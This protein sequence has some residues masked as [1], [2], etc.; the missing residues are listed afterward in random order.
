MNAQQGKSCQSPVW[1]ILPPELVYDP[2]LF[3]VIGK[4]NKSK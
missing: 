1:N 2:C 4:K 3:P